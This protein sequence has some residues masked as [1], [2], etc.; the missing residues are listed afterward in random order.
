MSIMQFFRYL[1]ET[2]LPSVIHKNFKSSNILLDNEL[3]PHLSESGFADL[4]P[5]EEFQV[6]AMH[7]SSDCLTT[8]FQELIT[9]LM[10]NHQEEM[11]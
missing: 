5:N 6:N 10:I 11:A 9:Q 1:H 3:N 4:I 8:C 2:C 7:I